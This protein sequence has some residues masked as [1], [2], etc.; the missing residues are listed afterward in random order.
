MN[1]IA[2]LGGTD[3]FGPVDTRTDGENWHGDWER[4]VFGLDMVVETLGLIPTDAVRFGVESVPPKH[5]LLMAY[6]EKW[7]T[8]LEKMLPIWGVLDPAETV[9]EMT[10]D[11]RLTESERDALV[12][13]V[14]A[15]IAA[16]APKTREVDVLPLFSVGDRVRARR[17][18]PAGHHRM[19]RYV[20]G[21]VG[22]VQRV[23]GIFVLP[24][25]VAHN[26]GEQPQPLYS[27]SFDLADLWSGRTDAVGAVNL[28]LYETYLEAL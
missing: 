24:D 6:Y 1:S 9:D 5:Y 27:V 3:G 22:T 28:D 15:A 18:H 19:P 21:C 13:G 25:A 8:S 26:M 14:L 4:K 12:E 17:I 11:E 10:I 16:G 7:L 2:D 20:R 23:H